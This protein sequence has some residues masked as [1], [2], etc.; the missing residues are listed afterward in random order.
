MMYASVVQI[1]NLGI[2]LQIRNWNT[3]LILTSFYQKSCS[4]TYKMFCNALERATFYRK[5]IREK[6]K[7][8]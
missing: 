7:G 1:L 2:L 8:D 4:I 5:L 6:V 3:P